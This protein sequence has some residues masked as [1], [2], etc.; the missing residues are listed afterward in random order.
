MLCVFRERAAGARQQVQEAVRATVGAGVFEVHP[1]TRAE[2]TIVRA[3]AGASTS[4]STS[5]STRPTHLERVAPE[6]RLAALAAHAV[7]VVPAHA[8]HA[9]ENQM[10]HSCVRMSSAN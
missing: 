4:T 6:E 9:Q 5:A 2:E 7:E 3:T 10:N 8:T 1:L